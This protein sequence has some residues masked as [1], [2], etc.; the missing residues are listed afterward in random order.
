MSRGRFGSAVEVARAQARATQRSRTALE[1]NVDSIPGKLQGRVRAA[2][3]VISKRRAARGRGF[4]DLVAGFSGQLLPPGHFALAATRLQEKVMRQK[5]KMP[6]MAVAPPSPYRIDARETRYFIRVQSA[7]RAM[8]TLLK[9][10]EF[11]MLPKCRR[12]RQCSGEHPPETYSQNFYNRFPPCVACSE[13]HQRLMSG[14]RDELARV[15]KENPDL[16][17]DGYDPFEDEED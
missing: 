17:W 5:E 11:C 12:A 9:N 8:A 10:Y 7:F 1:R 3:I 15:M 6:W 14:I 13:G 2:P 4:P 16:E